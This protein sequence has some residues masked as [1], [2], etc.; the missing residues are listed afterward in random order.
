MGRGG[1]G[2]GGPGHP[3]PILQR[4]DRGP[5]GRYRGAGDASGR[6]GGSGGAR[7]VHEP[8]RLVQ[9]GLLLARGAAGCPAGKPRRAGRGAAGPPPRNGVSERS[10]HSRCRS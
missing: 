3:G 2:R 4:R 7:A 8:D 10:R 9:G 6:G 5:P 1:S